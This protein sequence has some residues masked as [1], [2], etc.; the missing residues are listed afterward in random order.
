MSIEELDMKNLHQ[1][2][3]R[4]IIELSP[5]DLKQVVDTELKYIQEHADFTI[6]NVPAKDFEWD[7]NTKLFKIKRGYCRVTLHQVY[8]AMHDPKYKRTLE[9]N[10]ILGNN[11]I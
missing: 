4:V 11:N 6:K 9:K 8:K 3:W 2:D 5:K 10:M 1:T 7:A